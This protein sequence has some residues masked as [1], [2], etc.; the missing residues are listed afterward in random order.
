M[1]STLCYV[2]APFVF[3][4]LFAAAL[5]CNS[6]IVVMASMIAPFALALIGNACEEF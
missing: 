2:A 5:A 6:E 1:L 4:A 3:L